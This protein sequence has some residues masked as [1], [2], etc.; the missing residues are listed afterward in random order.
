MQVR[1]PFKCPDALEDA[2]ESQAEGEIGGGDDPELD[3]KFDVLVKECMR[4]AEKW[5]RHG[6]TITIVIDFDEMTC[7]VEEV[8]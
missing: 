4:K 7:T 6:E 1:I 3:Y 2:I 5:F 8:R